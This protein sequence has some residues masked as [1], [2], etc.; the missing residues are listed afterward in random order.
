MQCYPD[1]EI[2]LGICQT[3]C[4]KVL[5]HCMATKLEGPQY[6]ITSYNSLWKVSQICEQ[7]HVRMVSINPLAR[8]VISWNLG[9]RNL[10]IFKW[11]CFHF[12]MEA[13][14]QWFAGNQILARSEMAG[15]DSAALSSPHNRLQTNELQLQCFKP[16]Y[17]FIE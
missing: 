17:L 11:K 8:K 6:N 2:F 15:G 14:S 12:Q 7:W 9:D 5:S 10:Q 1:T 4:P 16:R 3:I 13:T